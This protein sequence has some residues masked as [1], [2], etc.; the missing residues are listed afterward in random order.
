MSTISIDTVPA[1]GRLLVWRPSYIVASALLAV[2]ARSE[3]LPFTL[4]SS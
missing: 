2:L 3:E 4:G 1:I